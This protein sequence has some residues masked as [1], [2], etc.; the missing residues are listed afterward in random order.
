M[1]NIVPNAL[2]IFNTSKYDKSPRPNATI[3]LI[4]LKLFNAPFRPFSLNRVIGSLTPF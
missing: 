2:S 4:S 3:V 1:S